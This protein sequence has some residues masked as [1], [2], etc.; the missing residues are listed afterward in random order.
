MWW[1]LVEIL[2]CVSRTGVCDNSVPCVALGYTNPYAVPAG[3][4]SLYITAPHLFYYSLPVR[5]MSYSVL[6]L[7]R[8]Y[9]GIS[10]TVG[11]EH[12]LYLYVIQCTIKLFY[13]WTKIRMIILDADLFQILLFHNQILNLIT[14]PV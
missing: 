4:A 9:A 10:C 2:I 11:S 14:Y 8:K 6:R 3:C 1:I 5:K 7:S 13:S 12:T